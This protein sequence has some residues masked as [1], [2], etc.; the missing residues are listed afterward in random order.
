MCAARNLNV[1]LDLDHRSQAF[2]VHQDSCG[3]SMRSRVYAYR[4]SGVLLCSVDSQ[5]ACPSR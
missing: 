2:D 1:L 4:C 3:V 5:T